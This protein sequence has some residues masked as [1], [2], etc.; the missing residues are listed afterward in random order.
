MVLIRTFIALF[1]ILVIIIL[2]MKDLGR[3]KDSGTSRTEDTGMSRME[4]SGTSRT[5][6]MGLNSAKN[7]VMGNDIV[8][9]GK[10]LASCRCQVFFTMLV[11]KFLGNYSTLK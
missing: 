8:I 6:D 7:T 4:D 3:T 2:S 5:E 1:M 11:L 9:I 10:D